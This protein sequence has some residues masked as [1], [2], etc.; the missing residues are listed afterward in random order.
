MSKMKKRDEYTCA[1]CGETYLCEWDDEE[2]WTEADSNGFGNIPNMDM[3]VVCDDCYKSMG[4]TTPM[5]C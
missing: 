1:D 3:V 2:A 5:G 4:F